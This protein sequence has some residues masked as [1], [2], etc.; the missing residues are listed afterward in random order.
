MQYPEKWLQ[1]NTLAEKI[2]NNLRLNIISGEIPSETILT[3]NQVS[4][5]FNTSRAPV[6]EAFKT[7][8]NEGIVELGRMGVK[9]LGLTKKDIDELYEFRFLI[10]DFALQRVMNTF[11]E[12]KAKEFTKIVQMM[13]LYAKHD[14]YLEFSYYDLQFHER[15]I[16][17]TNHKR[18]QYSWNNIR[19]ILLCLLIVATKKRFMED[20]NQI[21]KLIE[22]HRQLI[23]VLRS[24]DK[25]RLNR[26]VEE[27]S[28][29]TKKT[30][31]DAYFQ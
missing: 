15:I 17:E 20:N 16:I 21:N 7:L 1:H 27:H 11:D 2:T 12:E 24:Q 8:A 10:E 23:D 31:G 22:N 30:V 29:D 28:M 5:R 4:S 19:H 3:E 13:E 18:I 25:D 6:R 9:V 14:D 26:L